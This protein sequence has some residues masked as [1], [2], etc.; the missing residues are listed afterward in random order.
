[1]IQTTQSLTVKG[2]QGTDRWTVNIKHRLRNRK[3][4]IIMGIAGRGCGS[5]AQKGFSS[6]SGFLDSD[7]S[8]LDWEESPSFCAKRDGIGRAPLYE[9]STLSSSTH[10][11]GKRDSL[12]KVFLSHFVDLLCAGRQRLVCGRDEGGVSAN[13]P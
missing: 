1:M 9:R 4:I 3:V 10:V 8:P 2:I 12:C 7:S 5:R 11:E 13:A 6:S